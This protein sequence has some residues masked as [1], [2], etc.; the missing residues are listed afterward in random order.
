MKLWKWKFQLCDFER[1]LYLKMLL[2]FEKRTESDWLKLHVFTRDQLTSH[3]LRVYWCDRKCVQWDISSSSA[4]SRFSFLRKRLNEILE[5]VLSVLSM[6]SKCFSCVLSICSSYRIDRWFQSSTALWFDSSIHYIW[7][8]RP[9]WQSNC[10]VIVFEICH[11]DEI[12][13][14]H[15][16]RCMQKRHSH[17]IVGIIGRWTVIRLLMSSI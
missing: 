5:I 11:T 9:A 1:I 3:E 10:Q 15:V 17:A 6:W 2:C 7:H 8:S 14:I 16:S 12:L 13:L 4:S